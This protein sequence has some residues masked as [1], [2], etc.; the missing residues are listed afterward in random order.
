MQ[1]A[2]RR[3]SHSSGSV[4]CPTCCPV[5]HP[6]CLSPPLTYTLLPLPRLPSRP[7]DQQAAQAHADGGNHGGRGADAGG[8][9]AFV[10]RCWAL[11]CGLAVAQQSWKV[12]KCARGRRGKLAARVLYCACCECRHH[13]ASWLCRTGCWPNRHP[14]VPLLPLVPTS[15]VRKKRYNKL[16]EERSYWAKKKP[17]RKTENERRKKAHHRPKH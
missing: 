9:R 10:L 4:L 11:R 1:S 7:A 6:T 15:Q 13:D 3:N 12:Q 8:Q 5:L 16:Q 2:S 17:G 14:S